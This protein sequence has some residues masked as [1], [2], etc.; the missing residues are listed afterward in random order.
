MK[1]PHFPVVMT[2][3]GPHMSITPYA[4]AQMILQHENH[5]IERAT[6]FVNFAMD[7]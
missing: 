7:I 1:N 2:F 4:Q 5:S 3:Y 6:Y